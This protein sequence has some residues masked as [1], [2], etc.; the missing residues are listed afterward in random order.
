MYA[1]FPAKHLLPN[2]NQHSASFPLPL[3]SLSLFFLFGSYPLIFS[4]SF[5]LS[6]FSLSVSLSLCLRLKPF[7]LHFLSFSF[8]QSHFPINHLLH[9]NNHLS[10]KSS[11]T[12]IRHQATNT[13]AHTYTSAETLIFSIYTHSETHT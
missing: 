8:V 10:Y 9:Y 5:S 2:N 11:L 1:G 12:L 7:R 13:R 4:H 6:L 3:H